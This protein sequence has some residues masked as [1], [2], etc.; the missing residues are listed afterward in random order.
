MR[1]QGRIKKLEAEGGDCLKCAQ[2]EVKIHI[3]AQGE[4]PDEI[5][6]PGCGAPRPI[7]TFT[8]D[9]GDIVG[10]ER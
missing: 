7:V 10:A 3:K 4:P 8:L 2:G 6:C 9:I 1:L 5:P